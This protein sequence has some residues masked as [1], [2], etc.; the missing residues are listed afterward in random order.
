[1]KALWLFFFDSTM[2]STV[3]VFIEK[4]RIATGKPWKN[5]FLQVYPT[6]AVFPS[7]AEWRSAVYQSVLSS[8]R[9]EVKKIEK[10]ASQPKPQPLPQPQPQ[11]S[12]APVKQAAAIPPP[13]PK[14]NDVEQMDWVCGWCN[15]PAGN[16]H[17][18]CICRGYQYS[19][20]AWENGRIFPKKTTPK[21][22]NSPL[23]LE[24]KDWVRQ[25][26]SKA[27]LPA[28]RYYIGDLCYAL[29]DTL[30]DKVF[31]PCY[32]EGL[33]QSTKNPAHVFMMG[34][35]GGDGTFS[36][37]D[38]KEYSVDA[39]I[40][41]IAAEATLDPTKAPYEGGSLYTFT[42]PVNVALK[43]ERFTFYGEKYTD[44]RISISLYE[45]EE[46]TYEDSE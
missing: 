43:G 5:Q 20:E 33:F 16:D 45:D 15:K 1:M 17:R 22:T 12:S 30:Y 23:S 35:T 19:V 44:P 18:M 6:K 10:K 31:G 25:G 4:K 13:S 11:A 38:G 26:K 36:G 14:T 46:D 3:R 28:G 39:G 24:P 9:F 27:T 7:E 8:L 21:A 32:D 29:H 42:S 34:G 41:G 40:L 37:S 2:S